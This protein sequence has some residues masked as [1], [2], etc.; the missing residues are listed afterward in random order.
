VSLNSNQPV[1][2]GIWGKNLYNQNSCI[3]Y[4][5]HAQTLGCLVSFCIFCLTSMRVLL[6]V[7]GFVCVFVLLWVGTNYLETPHLQNVEGN[8]VMPSFDL[9]FVVFFF[10]KGVVNIYVCW[11]TLTNHLLEHLLLTHS[12]SFFCCCQV[13]LTQYCRFLLCP[14]R[15]GRVLWWA[16]LCVCPQE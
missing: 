14:S 10:T 15:W 16:C 1:S 5:W 2:W 9:K 6:F 7:V 8:F 3:V 4:K 12:L 13:Q 11:K